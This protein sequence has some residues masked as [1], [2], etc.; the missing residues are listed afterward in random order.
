MRYYM[1]DVGDGL[2]MAVRMDGSETLVH[3][4]CGGCYR[5]EAADPP[6]SLGGPRTK[7]RVMG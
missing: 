2:C 5:R 1:A 6:D 3:I 7:L 4:D